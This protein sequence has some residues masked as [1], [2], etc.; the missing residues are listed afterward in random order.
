MMVGIR[1]SGRLL[2]LRT[3]LHPMG[4]ILRRVPRFSFRVGAR[5][6]LLH[7][8]FVRSGR[9]LAVQ[10]FV[11]FGFFV[12]C[13]VFAHP[14]VGQQQVPLAV[15]KPKPNANA[16][17]IVQRQ[18]KG[19]FQNELELVEAICKP[20]REQSQKLLDVAESQWRIKT[21][22]E[23]SKRLQQHV[24][25][26]VD[27]DGLVERTIQQWVSEILTAEQ[28]AA[29]DAEL[30][31]RMEFRKNAL[32]TQILVWLQSKLQLSA[33]QQDQVEEVLRAKW[34]DRWFRSIEATFDNETLL[35]ELNRSWLDSILTDAQRNALAIRAPQGRVEPASQEYSSYPLDKRFLMSGLESSDSILLDANDERGEP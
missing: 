25:G 5:P 24:Y 2:H 1:I 11:G 18:V 12:V 23:M 34:K 19:L 9:G 8:G 20:N 21:R 26:A 28:S 30:A 3:G 10:P 13:V 31:D 29:Y 4:R 14:L 27:F 35:P 6:G 16:K 15:I 22:R 7:T 17:W 32:I 33:E